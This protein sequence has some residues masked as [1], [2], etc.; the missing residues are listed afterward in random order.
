MNLTEFVARVET[1]EDIHTEFKSGPLLQ[2][3]RAKTIIKEA[4]HGTS[5]RQSGSNHW[6]G[7]RHW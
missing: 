7:V 2:M 5:G 6:W 3:I 1:W 4:H